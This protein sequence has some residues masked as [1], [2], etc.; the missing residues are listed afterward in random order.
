M[1]TS[2]PFPEFFFDDFMK[3]NWVNKATCTLIR[4][5]LK[6]CW[7]D[8]KMIT[9]SDW[10]NSHVLDFEMINAVSMRILFELIRK[11]LIK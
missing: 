9:P 8:S 2:F 10:A 1:L 6:G 5:I 4:I 3:I 7:P 11:L